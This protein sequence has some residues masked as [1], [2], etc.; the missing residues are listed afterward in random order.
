M[1]PIK[2]SIVHAYVVSESCEFHGELL[3]APLR[4]REP[5]YLAPEIYVA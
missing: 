5:L 2:R 3:E 1:I 4:E